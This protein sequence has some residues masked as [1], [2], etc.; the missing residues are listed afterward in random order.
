M[1]RK[2]AEAALAKTESVRRELIH[3]MNGAGPFQNLL[4][5]L[6]A[7]ADILRNECH[8]TERNVKKYRTRLQHE[9]GSEYHNAYVS[10]DTAIA[11]MR[12]AFQ[13]GAIVAQ[14]R[15]VTDDV[16][17]YDGPTGVELDFREW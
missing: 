10:A 14:V 2:D 7:V 11:R 17:I 12:E 8:A 6:S 3:L 1:R 4:S 16:V 15:R 9:G 5:D 13:A